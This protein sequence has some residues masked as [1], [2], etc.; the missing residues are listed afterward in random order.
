MHCSETKAPSLHRRYPASPVLRAYTSSPFALPCPRR[1]QVLALASNRCRGLP[2][3]LLI[4]FACM[5]PPIPRRT[6]A[7]LVS[8]AGCAMTAFPVLKPG[9][10]PRHNLGTCS[11]FIRITPARSLTPF[12][13]AFGAEGFAKFIASQ[14]ASAATGWSESC[15]VG[16]IHSPTGVPRL[17]TAHFNRLL[18]WRHRRR[19]Q[20]GDVFPLRPNFEWNAQSPG[21]I[22]LELVFRPCV[23][24]CPPMSPRREY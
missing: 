11:M 4:S 22:D 5:S 20:F 19:L 24:R 6:D 3:L 9:R 12:E 14:R 7:L 15:R 23:V 18:G 8:L 2:L 17:S 10:S 13:G 16:F 21:E 1:L